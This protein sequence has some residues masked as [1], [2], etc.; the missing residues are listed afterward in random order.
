MKNSF[1]SIYW[2]RYVNYIKGVVMPCHV[3]GDLKDMEY[4]R[5]ELF[6]C[7]LIYIAPLSIIALLPSIYM[8]FSNGVPLVGFADI[9]AFSFVIMLMVNRGL[10]LPLRKTIFISIIYLLSVILLYELS[11]SGAGLLFLLTTT[12]LTAIIYSSVAAIY[13]AWINTFICLFF[14]VLIGLRISVPFALEYSVGTWLAI[15]SNLVLLSFLC[16]FCLKLLMKGIET[17]II[18]KK[19]SEANLTAIIE[20]TTAYIYSIDRD[21]RYL[22]FNSV[23]SQS[24]KHNYGIDIKKG[25]KVYGYLEETDRDESVWW[26]DTYT[27]AL[28]GK[29]MQFEKDY[30]T[31]NLPNYTHFSINPIVENKNVVGLSCFVNDITKQ[32]EDALQKEKMSADLMR[33]NQDLE[34]FTFIISHD[35]RAPTANI[36]G[37]A[38]ILQD[39][40]LTPQEQREFLQGLSTSV[41]GLDTTIKD[42]NSILQVK[43][44][45]SGEKEIIYFSKL[46]N[47]ITISI[48]NLIDKHSVRIISDFLDVDEFYSFKVYIY[49]VFYNLISNSIKYSKPNEQP[50]IEIKSKKENGKII[51]T[52]KDN[53]LGIDL[54]TKGDKIFGLYKRFHS[55]VEGKGMGLFMVKIQVESLG[56]KITIAS[57]PYKGTEFTIIFET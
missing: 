8:S 34:Q 43:R 42:L 37:Y 51:L 30:S 24:M 3:C 28:T 12:I 1:L 25:D 4:W 57:E 21:F 13:S 7:I 9:F 11:K 56:G 54:K 47:D 10:T 41:A 35:L 32:K 15:S 49:S 2:S 46:V 20:N 53:G 26:F 31:A 5:N 36:I 19:T 40:T 44:E 18:D 38:D 55:H 14:G 48:S 22:T 52:F 29:P 6:C 17:Y 23:L 50:I 45:V 39:E 16:A 27:E 33:R